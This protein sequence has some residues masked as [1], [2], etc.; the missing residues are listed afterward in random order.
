MTDLE[1]WEEEGSIGKNF[2]DKLNE[3]G[4]I[5]ISAMEEKSKDDIEEELPEEYDMVDWTVRKNPVCS[6]AMYNEEDETV[7]FLDSSGSYIDKA[8]KD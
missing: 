7:Y 8:K 3:E 2:K 5:P 6:Q 4:Y 1:K